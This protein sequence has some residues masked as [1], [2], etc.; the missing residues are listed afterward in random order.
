MTFR[1]HA[2]NA[3][4]IADKLTWATRTRE[5]DGVKVVLVPREQADAMK[6]QLVAISHALNDIADEQ[7]TAN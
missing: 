6:D 1:K 4:N 3:A 5:V 7:D 2:L